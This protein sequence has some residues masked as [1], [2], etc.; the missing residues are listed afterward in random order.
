MSEPHQLL[1]RDY[2]CP[3]LKGHLYTGNQPEVVL[4]SK[5]RSPTCKASI[6]VTELY[7]WSKKTWDTVFRSVD[8]RAI[9]KFLINKLWAHTCIV[10]VNKDF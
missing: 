5:I 2:S 1:L 8:T 9:N 4:V 10:I 3:L 7:P 6:P